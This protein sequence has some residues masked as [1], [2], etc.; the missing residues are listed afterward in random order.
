MFPSRNKKPKSEKQSSQRAQAGVSIN[1]PNSKDEIGVTASTLA[2][3]AEKN[4][5]Q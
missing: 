2:S 3:K 4:M 5:L 1:W